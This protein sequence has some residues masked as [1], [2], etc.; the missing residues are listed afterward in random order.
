MLFLS[1]KMPDGDAQRTFPA[2]NPFDESQRF[3][4]GKEKS[5][6][7]DRTGVREITQR[8]GSDCKPAPT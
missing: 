2:L 7:P 8:S 3:M 6:D 5:S 4:K 1:Q